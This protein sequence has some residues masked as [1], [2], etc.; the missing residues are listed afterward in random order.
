MG[1]TP[2]LPA[3]LEIDLEDDFLVE[4]DEYQEEETAGQ[5]ATKPAPMAPASG[6][7]IFDI[8]TGP[9]PWAEIEQFFTPP[10]A[11]GEFDPAAVKYGNTKAADKRAI[12]LAEAKE[13]HALA[14]ASHAQT[15]EAAKAEFLDK[16]ALSPLTGQVLAIGYLHADRK[17]EDRAVLKYQ[18]EHCAA[19]EATILEEFWVLY[20]ITREAGGQIVGHNIYGFDLP[21]MIRRS[22][23]LAV[24]VPPDVLRDG[25]YWSKVFIDTMSVWGCGAYKDY[26][27]LDDLA[28][29]FGVG[30]KPGDCSGADFARMFNASDEERA[31]ALEYLKND[32]TMTWGVAR[33]MGVC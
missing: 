30:Q 26:T 2:A 12:I 17:P 19:T 27:S 13:K 32:L 31:T 9:R 20:E 18:G 21:F 10:A 24:E 29:F 11:P 23:L 5:P 8:E 1:A 28:R 25:R 33:K 4:E 14:V 3:D 15:I 7:V 22:W 6:I 16:A